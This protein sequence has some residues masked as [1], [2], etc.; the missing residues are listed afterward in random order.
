MRPHPYDDANNIFE[1]KRMNPNYY[2]IIMAGG[3]GSRFWPLSRKN[4]PKQFLDILNTGNTLFQSTYNRLSKLCLAE[5][6]YVVTNEAYRSIIK[7][8]VPDISD[9]QI[10]GEPQARNT[11]PCIAYGAFKIHSLN[12]NAVMAVVP[13]DHLIGDEENFNKTFLKAFDFAENNPVLLTLGIKPT[14]PDTGYGYIQYEEEH[15]GGDIFKVKTF[16]EK[17]NLEL[18]KQFVSSGDF[19]WNSGMFIWSSSEIIKSLKMHIPDL[20]ESFHR[21]VSNFRTSS[22]T[23]FIR[24]I[25][26]TCPM[27][28]IDY[29]VMEKSRNVHVM[30]ADFDWSDIGTWDG[31]YAVAKKDNN[32]NSVSGEMTFLRNTSDTMVNVPKNVMVALNNVSNLIVVLHDNILLIADKAKEQEIKQV[33]NDIKVAYG[34][35]FI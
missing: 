2:G 12:P 14:R 17:P 4:M 30:P 1:V 25:Y 8:Q 21:G 27:I 10:L 7:E 33:V 15:G 16:T 34:D 29:G 6:I 23:E 22:E 31:L 26:E 24:K 18:A 32:G 35:R 28:S 13:S 20:Y 9:E 5:N 19:V 11:A 3:V